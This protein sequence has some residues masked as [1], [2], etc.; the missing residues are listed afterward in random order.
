VWR[1]VNPV[2]VAGP[3][4]NGATFPAFRT[5][6]FRAYRYPADYAGLAGRD[7]TPGPPLETDTDGDGLSD[8]A[9]SVVSGTNPALPDTDDDGFSDGEEASAGSDP[10]DPLSTPLTITPTPTSTPQ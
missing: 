1:Y 9:E 3:V 5:F 4:V 7:L 6:L 10:T 2:T 8:E